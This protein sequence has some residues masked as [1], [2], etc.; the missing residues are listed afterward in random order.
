ME[1][2]V[3]DLFR[4]SDDEDTS[5]KI[6]RSATKLLASVIGTRPE[7]LPALYKS[8]SPVLISRFGDREESVRLEVWAAYSLLVMQTG[9]YG[10][11]VKEN[12]FSPIVGK[13]KREEEGEMD[14]EESPYSLLRFQVPS[15]AKKLLKQLQ[16][17]KVSPATLQAG[18]NLLFSLLTVLPG[19]LGTQVTQIFN[20]TRTVLSQPSS[21]TTSSLQ[22]TVLSF[23]ALFF[24]THSANLFETSLPTIIPVLLVSVR[25]KHPRVAAETF[26]VFS[27]LLT[28]LRPMKPNQWSFTIYEEA[29]GRLQANDTDSDVR[30]C[31]G[32]LIGDLWISN[33]EVVKGKGGEEWQA[34]LKHGGR[35]DGPLKVIKRVAI[36]ANMDDQ[37]INNSIE[38]VL[39]ILKKSGRAGKVDA[40]A[41]L[42]S[43]IGK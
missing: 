35:P 9:V 25:E 40:F 22:V 23:L 28:T 30:D 34:M 3:Y 20:L 17:L 27:S 33:P 1:R 14:I 26:R 18:F 5:Y 42:N 16:V 19:S 31:A 4:Y 7:L 12:D 36:Q 32:E 24:K 39:N 11:N 10:G 6:R 15:L 8:V 21:T 29:V 43:L 13:R 37:W 38:W 2:H 41:T